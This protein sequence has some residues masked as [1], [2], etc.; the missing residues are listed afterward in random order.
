[1]AINNIFEDDYFIST[2]EKDNKEYLRNLEIQEYDTKNAFYGM[3]KCWFVLTKITKT[4]MTIHLNYHLEDKRFI[5][6]EWFR[7]SRDEEP[8]FNYAIYNEN[9]N[10]IV[11]NHFNF[12]RYFIFTEFTPVKSFKFWIDLSNRCQHE[13]SSIFQ[14]DEDFDLDNILIKIKK[15]YYLSNTIYYLINGN[16]YH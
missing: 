6:S 1:M 15:Y 16:Y 5:F 12:D 4:L 8:N 3:V 9:F 10:F 2:F 13:L 7:Y 14:S 11:K